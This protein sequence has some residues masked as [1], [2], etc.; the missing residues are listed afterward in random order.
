[1]PAASQLLFSRMSSP[2]GAEHLPQ[3]KARQVLQAVSAGEETVIAK[4][5]SAEL[6]DAKVV[7]CRLLSALEGTTSELLSSVVLTKVTRPALWSQHRRVWNGLID[8]SPA[9]IVVAR[10]EDDVCRTV[11]VA[12]ELNLELTVKGGGHNVGGCCG[13]IASD[14]VPQLHCMA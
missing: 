14:A 5:D 1:M 3:L 13:K 10:S 11:A 12:L 2:S 9:L 4:G 8:R 6:V 7:L